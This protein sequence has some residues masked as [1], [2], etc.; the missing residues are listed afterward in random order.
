MAGADECDDVGANFLVGQPGA[1]LRI[2][3][4]EQKRQEIFRRGLS[5]V[6]ERFPT[7]DDGIDRG[8]EKFDGV[9][10]AILRE[11]R[12]PFREV[13]QIGR[14]EDADR[15]EEARH[16]DHEL[17]G[18]ALEAARKDRGPEDVEGNAMH[19]RL[20]VD[21]A[22]GPDAAPPSCERLGGFGHGIRERGDDTRREDRGD[23]AALDAP[24][25]AFDREQAVAETGRK[26]ALLQRVLA[27]IGDIVEE[28]ATD[29]GRVTDHGADPEQNRGRSGLDVRNG[30]ASRSRSDCAEA[31]GGRQEDAIAQGAA[32]APVA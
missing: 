18:I 14:V 11:A 21:D 4:L 13:E 3:R 25:L 7:G 32:W 19:V 8:F 20:D 28:D 15:R 10:A 6:E 24:G 29:R 5:R 2:R 27:I 16:R 26:D 1:G 31:C 23:G 17:V 22:S 12:H 30:L 9:A